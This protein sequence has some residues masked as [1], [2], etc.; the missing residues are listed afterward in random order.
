[1]RCQNAAIEIDAVIELYDESHTPRAQPLCSP[2]TP[3]YLFVWLDKHRPLDPNSNHCC[4]TNDSNKHNSCSCQTDE[5]DQVL[6]L[7]R[8]F[9]NRY[10][11]ESACVAYSDTARISDCFRWAFNNIAHFKRRLVLMHREPILLVRKEHS[12]LPALFKSAFLILCIML[13]DSR[14]VF[15]LAQALATDEDDHD[16]AMSSSLS[17][18]RASSSSSLSSSPLLE[19][20]V[21]QQDLTPLNALHVAVL[22]SNAAAL[23]IDPAYLAL[24]DPA[25]ET[26]AWLEQHSLHRRTVVPLSK[27][28]FAHQERADNIIH[29]LQCLGLDATAPGLLYSNAIDLACKPHVKRLLRGVGMSIVTD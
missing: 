9:A 7:F 26:R 24:I 19:L 4:N 23:Q 29:L 28:S 3:P 17:C 1:M 8:A 21:D 2:Y 15:D 22:Q 14:G 5:P 18:S 16:L 12:E 13:H 11:I 20:R 6:L 25:L 10:G 27:A